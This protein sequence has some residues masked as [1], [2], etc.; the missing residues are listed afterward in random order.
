M[1]KNLKNILFILFL[2]L[3]AAPTFSADKKKDDKKTDTPKAPAVSLESAYI[4]VA[5]IT[6]STEFN[7]GVRAFHQG[8]YNK[9]LVNF[10]KAVN[11][12]PTEA[13]YRLWLGFANFYTGLDDA[14][15]SQWET[16]LEEDKALGG[17]WLKNKIE[18]INFRHSPYYYQ[19]FTEDSWVERTKTQE[20]LSTKS[21]FIKPTSVKADLLSSDVFVVS[22]ASN[23]VVRYDLNGDVLSTYKGGLVP[24][25]APFDIVSLAD[26]RFFVSE[27]GANRISLMSASGKRLNSFGNSKEQGNLSGP[28]FIETDY[29]GNLFIS[30]SGNKRIAK[31]DYEGNFLMEIGKPSPFFDGLKDPAGIALSYKELFVIDRKD[32]SIHVFDHSGNYIKTMAKD[33]FNNPEGLNI[34]KNK[35]IIIADANKLFMLNI[36]DES[37]ITLSDLN[38]GA[39]RIY[40]S[41]FDRN[42]SLVLVDNETNSV[43]YLKRLSDIYSG[44]SV[45]IKR[46][47]TGSWPKISLEVAVKNHSGNNIFGLKDTN[48]ILLENGAAPDVDLLGSRIYVKK[49]PTNNTSS[50]LNGALIVESSMESLMMEN[51]FTKGL[52]DLYENIA[53]KGNLNYFWASSIPI[54]ETITN[55]KDAVL[56]YQR[57]SKDMASDKWSFDSTVRLAA[58]S[59]IPLKQNHNQAIFFLTTGIDNQSNYSQYQITEIINYL[60]N[61]NIAFYP[62]YLDYR[63]HNKNYDYI[64]EQTGGVSS[65]IYRPEGLS[66]LL[67]IEQKR[68]TGIYYIDYTTKVGGRQEYI[69]QDIDLEVIL[70][71]ERGKTKMGFFPPL[72]NNGNTK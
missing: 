27:F 36:E 40:Q 42:N 55:A 21:Q 14:A 63:Y 33:K 45:D 39:K 4:D 3:I 50:M 49:F 31:Y 34:Y 22:Y 17:A 67:E 57:K 2:V 29:N 26:G 28:Q 20:P 16:L 30:D 71:K 66:S 51:M 35:Y 58:N 53:S 8:Y 41:T 6:A 44:L 38:T 48:F 5:S 9:A 43:I 59:L 23:S 62:I 70:D 52:N 69:Y 47:D 61:N 72:Q 25:S 18:S 1:K 12:K 56:T 68:D 37:V 60:I 54:A 64:A 15:L 32:R 11:L 46:V 24:F 10:E 65:Y 19:E 13:I 7:W